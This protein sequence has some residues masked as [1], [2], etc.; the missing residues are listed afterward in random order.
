MKL[1]E[2]LA[3]IAKRSIVL[4]RSHA[5]DARQL[6]REIGPVTLTV[7]LGMQQAVDVVEDILASV[8]TKASNP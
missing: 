3:G 8:V 6:L 5:G 1:S 7:V 2:P 4:D